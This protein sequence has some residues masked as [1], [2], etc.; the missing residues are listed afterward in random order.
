M[1]FFV[2]NQELPSGRIR[3]GNRSPQYD[4]GEKLEHSPSRKTK[5]DFIAIRHRQCEMGNFVQGLLHDIVVMTKDI[6]NIIQYH[7][8]KDSIMVVILYRGTDIHIKHICCVKNHH[9]SD[10][11]QEMRRFRADLYKISWNMIAVKLQNSS[12][13]R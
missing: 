9:Q 8:Q 1:R 7:F 13:S 3:C 10:A 4:T 11:L 6:I 2:G 5:Q 12:Y